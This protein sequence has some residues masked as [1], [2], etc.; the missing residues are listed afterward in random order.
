MDDKADTKHE[1]VHLHN[2]D[3]KSAPSPTHGGTD[4]GSAAENWHQGQFDKEAERKLLRK[5]DLR[6]IPWLSFLYV[7]D[8]F[9]LTDME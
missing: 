2:H 5:I 7:T 3:D 1:A 4:N 9:C 8:S 6:L